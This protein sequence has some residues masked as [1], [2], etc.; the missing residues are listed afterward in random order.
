MEVIFRNQLL[1]HQHKD[2]RSGKRCRHMLPRCFPQIH[3]SP[4]ARK[5]HKENINIGLSARQTVWVMEAMP[6]KVQDIK[7]K[8]CKEEQQ[9]DTVYRLFLCRYLFAEQVK[10]EKH[11]HRYSAINIRPV[12]QSDFRLHVAD[13]T[14]DHIENR[15]I[16]GKCLWKAHIS[17]SSHLQGKDLRKQNYRRQTTRQQGIHCKLESAPNKFFPVHVLIQNQQGDKIQ[18]HKN[19]GHDG[20]IIIGKNGHAKR[21][22]VE[23][24]FSVFHKP[25]QSQNDQWKQDNA[26]Q[27]HDIPA[28]S[29][30]IS[31]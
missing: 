6:D 2:H 14:R 9:H 10:N 11:Q 30:H 27:P 31:R 19:A 8:A 4:V 7:R 16:L 15:K 18:H 21:Q 17:G 5:Q 25:F 28:V 12:I 24:S 13:M 3:I 20:D 22:A 29:R 26:V 23:H 1:C